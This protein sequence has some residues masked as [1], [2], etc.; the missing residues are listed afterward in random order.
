MLIQSVSLRETAEF[1]EELFDLVERGFVRDADL[2]E[3]CGHA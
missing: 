2:E 3:I 1:L